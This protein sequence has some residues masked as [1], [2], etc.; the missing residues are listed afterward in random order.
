MLLQEIRDLE[1]VTLVEKQR[2][3]EWDNRENQRIEMKNRYRLAMGLPPL[4][5]D[6][7]VKKAKHGVNVLDDEDDDHSK[8]IMLN[9]AA[10]ILADYII[11]QHET[12]IVN[13]GNPLE[14]IGN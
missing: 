7:D 9:E 2:K 11:G 13:R 3:L 5:S 6:D 12:I 8:K 10:K 4:H 14:A 1:L